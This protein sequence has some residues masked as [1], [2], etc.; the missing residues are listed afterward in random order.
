M[1]CKGVKMATKIKH[2]VGVDV[3]PVTEDEA[4]EFVIHHLSLAAAYYE[5]TPNDS[6]N[7]LKEMERMM[8]S[9]I[10]NYE[11]PALKAARAWFSTIE[12][13]FERMRNNDHTTGN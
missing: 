1:T 10:Q 11:T 7:N 6:N 12:A 13:D 8:A 9:G 2:K 4:L 3:P 5:A